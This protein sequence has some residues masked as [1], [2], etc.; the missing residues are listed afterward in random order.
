MQRQYKT[1]YEYSEEEEII[2]KSRFIAY[3]TPV[4][5]EQEAIEFIDKIK[6]QHKMATHNVP[7]YVLGDNY[8]IQR[9]SDDGEPSGTAGL[10]I[11]EMIKKEDI[12][13]MAIV[14]TR[15]FGGT[16][17]GTG[18]LVRAYTSSAKLA[19]KKAKV[20][21]KI[22]HDL[23]QIKIEYTL[24]GKIQ[25]ELMN[26]NYIIKDT[27]FNEKV[28]LYIYSTIDK[29]QELTV[30]IKNITSGKTDV[31]LEDT[32]YLDEIDGKILY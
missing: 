32:V 27:V 18:G 16:K 13:D 17:L 8:Q 12:K 23:V 9:Y 20:V 4:K 5:T 29:T 22:L 28:S 6:Q 2:Q 14:V 31:V 25:N 10:P 19:I 24:L 26:N 11:L 30:L 21:N 15:Y 1:L 3:A 7:V